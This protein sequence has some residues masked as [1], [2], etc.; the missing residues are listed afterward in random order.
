MN[1]IAKN[2]FRKIRKHID[3]PNYPKNVIKFDGVVVKIVRK[4]FADFINCR[5]YAPAFLCYLVFPRLKIQYIGSQSF[6][7]AIFF[8]IWWKVG[9]EKRLFMASAS[10]FF[11]LNSFYSRTSSLRYIWFNSFLIAMTSGFHILK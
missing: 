7:T 3:S 5:L 1:I 6:M 10:D 9:V 4:K 2:D 8:W 11:S